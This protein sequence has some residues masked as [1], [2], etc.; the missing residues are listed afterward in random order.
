MKQINVSY[1]VKTTF[2]YKATNLADHSS[3]FALRGLVTYRLG[4]KVGLYRV[5][6]VKFLMFTWFKF[7]VNSNL[8]LLRL[9]KLFLGD[10][11]QIYFNPP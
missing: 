9:F 11:G 8:P 5:K 4:G 1:W 3:A 7:G 2:T 10:L 6:S